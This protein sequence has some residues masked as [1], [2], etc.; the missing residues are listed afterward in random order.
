MP[1]QLNKKASPLIVILAFAIVYIVWG[2]TYFFIQKALAGFP[3]FILGAFRFLAAGLLLITWCSIKGEKIFDKKSIRQAA[4]AGILMLGIGNGLV[5][6]VEQ[7]IPSG[8]V[9]ILVSS[10]AMWFVILDKPK[11][12]ENLQSTSTVMGLIIGFIGVIL[13]FAEQVMHTLNNNQSNTQI[14]GIVL[15]LLAPIGWAAGSLYSKY[16]TTSAVSVSVNTS[17]QML[18]AGIAFTPGILFNSELKNFDW[19]MVSADAWLSVGYLVI[20]GSIAAFSAYVWLLSV[21]PATQVSTYAYVNPVV[22]V[23]LSVLFTSEKVTIIQ[24]AGLV[25]ILGSVLLI[26]LAKYRKEHQ[27]KQKTTYSK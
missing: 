5:I 27:L 4:I 20:F 12:K 2:S 3:P 22:A 26:N 18:A 1:S 8:L 23:L 6:W 16:N 9:A 17:W 14:V 7:S 13:L 15:L 25:V 11:W 19:H 21:R 24:V 10:A